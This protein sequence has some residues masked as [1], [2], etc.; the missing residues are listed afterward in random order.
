MT[1]E[2]ILNE[3]HERTYAVW[4]QMSRWELSTNEAVRL[5][6]QIS[7]EIQQRIQDE[8]NRLLTIE[9]LYR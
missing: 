5:S 6:G 1:P 3:W 8:V 7:L 4:E 2:E 9:G